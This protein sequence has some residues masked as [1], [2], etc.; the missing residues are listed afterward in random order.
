MRNCFFL[1]L[2]FGSLIIASSA[3]AESKRHIHETLKGKLVRDFPVFPLYPDSRLIASNRK[4]EDGKSGYDAKYMAKGT[5]NEVVAYY[6]KVLEPLGWKPKSPVTLPGSEIEQS[7]RFEK[8]Q[9]YFYL[10]VEHENDETEISLEVPMQ[11]NS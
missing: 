10:N 2:L 9:K 3:T 11:K 6:L 4:V 8:D 1:F 5:V 7:I